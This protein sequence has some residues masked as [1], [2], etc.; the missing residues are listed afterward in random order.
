LYQVVI[1]LRE[2]ELLSCKSVT[3]GALYWMMMGGWMPIG[4][5]ARIEFDARRA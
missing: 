2:V 1:A 4:S 5:E 3:P